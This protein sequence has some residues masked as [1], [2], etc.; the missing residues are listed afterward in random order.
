MAGL[1]IPEKKEVSV[2]HVV[3]TSLV[4]SVT[5]VMKKLANAT[6]C[7]TLAVEIVQFVKLTTF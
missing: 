7:Q 6:V 4:L 3:V 2:N 5:S 1:D